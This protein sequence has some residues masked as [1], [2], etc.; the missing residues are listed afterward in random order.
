[1]IRLIKRLA[2]K[3]ADDHPELTLASCVSLA[4]SSHINVFSRLED[5]RQSS[6]PLKQRMRARIHCYDALWDR[7]FPDISDEQIS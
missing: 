5:T 3:L 4:C 1:M 2:R 6:G 7:D